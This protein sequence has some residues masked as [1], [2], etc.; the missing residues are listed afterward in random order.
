MLFVL[1]NPGNIFVSSSPVFYLV[2][3]FN[4]NFLD[5]PTPL[6]HKLIS[7]VS[8]FNLTQI[9]SEPTRV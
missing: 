6:Y 3:D 7:V 4:I 2:G 5:V 8:S 1:L 9:V